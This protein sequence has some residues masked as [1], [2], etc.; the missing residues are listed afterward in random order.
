MAI[1]LYT[2]FLKISWLYWYQELRCPTALDPWAIWDLSQIQNPHCWLCTLQKDHFQHEWTLSRCYSRRAQCVSFMLFHWQIISWLKL[3]W[4]T[5]Y[6][7]QE[8]CYMYYLPWGDDYSKEAALWASIPCP[9]SKV[10]ARAPAH[11]PYVQS[12][13]HSP[14]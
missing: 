7:I 10:M 6:C 8:W 5:F 13:N 1:D 2:S 4:F 3:L 14:R 12:S 9:L 11:L